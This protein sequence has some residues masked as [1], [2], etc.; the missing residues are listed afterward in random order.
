MFLGS[1]E[2]MYVMIIIHKT[3]IFSPGLQKSFGGCIFQ[4]EAQEVKLVF[5]LVQGSAN[6]GL[7]DKSS[8]VLDN[9]ASLEHRRH[10]HS[11]TWSTIV[12]VL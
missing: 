12:F 10:S 9:Q 4:V 7:Q 6:S 11:F 1:K 3:K 5:D 2:K 8:P